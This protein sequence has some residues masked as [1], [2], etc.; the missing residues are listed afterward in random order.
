MIEKSHDSN[1]NSLENYGKRAEKNEKTDSFSQYFSQDKENSSFES[2]YESIVKKKHESTH[3]FNTSNQKKKILIERKENTNKIQ[4]NS[5][6]KKII[7]STNGKKNTCNN[8]E[9]KKE[10]VMRNFKRKLVNKKEDIS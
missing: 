7:S 2:F 5:Y 4:E 1:E 3:L 8:K 10:G 6:I 9:N